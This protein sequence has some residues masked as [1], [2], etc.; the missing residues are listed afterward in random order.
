MVKAVDDLDPKQIVINWDKIA[1]PGLSGEQIEFFDAIWLMA[2][3]HLPQK[4]KDTFLA[5]FMLLAKLFGWV[6][7]TAQHKETIRKAE[8][9]DIA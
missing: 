4:D 5:N 8:I 6:N 9:G 2:I 3:D 1:L 7:L